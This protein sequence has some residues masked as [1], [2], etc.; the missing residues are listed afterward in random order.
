[1]SF[2]TSVRSQG[3][4]LLLFPFCEG[5]KKLIDMTVPICPRLFLGD[6]TSQRISKNLPRR[7]KL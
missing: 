6:C 1:M 7:G 2:L 5:R 3:T 4:T